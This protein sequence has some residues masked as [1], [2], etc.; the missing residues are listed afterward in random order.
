MDPVF[1]R[2]SQ[3]RL[4]H[5]I[6][7]DVPEHYY[8][9]KSCVNPWEEML[10]QKGF[11]SKIMYPV[12]KNETTPEISFVRLNNIKITLLTSNLPLEETNTLTRCFHNLVNL[13]HWFSVHNFDLG[14]GILAPPKYN[15]HVHRTMRTCFRY[16]KLQQSAEALAL[17]QKN[18]KLEI[19]TKQNPICQ[20]ALLVFAGL[21]PFSPWRLATNELLTRKVVLQKIHSLYGRKVDPIQITRLNSEMA[22]INLLIRN[23]DN[24]NRPPNSP[25]TNHT[26]TDKFLKELQNGPYFLQLEL[27]RKRPKRKTLKVVAGDD[28]FELS[29][30]KHN[31]LQKAI[32]EHFHTDGCSLLYIGDTVGKN[33]GSGRHLIHKKEKIASLAIP[34]DLAGKLPDIL[35]HD[36][37]NNTIFVIEAH[38]V[39]GTIDQAKKLTFDSLLQHF[40][41]TKRYITAY[42]DRK[43]FQ[44]SVQNV[45]WG[46]EVWI[47]DEPTHLIKFL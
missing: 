36:P 16:Y 29:L 12:G 30:G 31:E 18:G 46:T 24:E 33:L 41:G 7:V 28:H 22:G 42:A 6:G 20:R 34:P 17:I 11:D 40:T 5:S 14:I 44:S 39:T 9:F 45:M 1:L 4:C 27:D 43:T 21:D 8:L 35:I 3:T 32:V 15:S 26:I 25:K 10:A 2:Y 37:K 13:K 47:A 23:M 38:N 19:I